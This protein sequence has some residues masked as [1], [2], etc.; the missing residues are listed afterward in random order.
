M[1]FYEGIRKFQTGELELAELQSILMAELLSSP[2]AAQD[3]LHLIDSIFT[4]GRLQTEVYSELRNT[5]TGNSSIGP[6]T[7]SQRPQTDSYMPGPP[8]DDYDPAMDLSLIH[9]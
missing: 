5:I 4:K 7:G 3:C 1:S 9:I 8:L 6:P 2:N